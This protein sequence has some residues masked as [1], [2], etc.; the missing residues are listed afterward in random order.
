MSVALIRLLADVSAHPSLAPSAGD[1]GGPRQWIAAAAIA[2]LVIGLA[3]R[4]IAGRRL[5]RRP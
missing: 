3:F 5:R 2:A 4:F 1:H